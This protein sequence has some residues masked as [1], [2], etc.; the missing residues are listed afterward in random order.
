[1]SFDDRPS[2]A[3]AEIP[4]DEAW[5][6]VVLAWDDEA[7]HQRYL[8]RFQSLE[9]LVVAGGRYKAVLAEK[10]DDALAQRMRAE[11]LKKATAYGFAAKIRISFRRSIPTGRSSL[12]AGNPPN[13]ST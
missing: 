12:P 9:A 4:E 7:A 5:A 11:V 2:D 13:R 8:A 3:A 1:M 10:P 6:E